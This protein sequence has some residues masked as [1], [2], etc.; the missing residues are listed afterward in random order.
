MQRAILNALPIQKLA[1]K[2]EFPT[3]LI[4]E[5]M[6]PVFMEKCVFESRD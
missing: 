5:E 4:E 2:V 6:K 1:P 3:E